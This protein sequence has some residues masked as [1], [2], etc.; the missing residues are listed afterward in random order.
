MHIAY[1]CMVKDMEMSCDEA[2]IAA[3]SV[4][5]RQYANA[6]LQVVAR[7]QNG[8]ALSAFA[9]GSIRSASPMC[10][11]SIVWAKVQLC[12]GRARSASLPLC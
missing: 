12:A 8:Y 9:H 2:A 10:L 5:R 4:D 7:P 3:L 6:L 1:R 11:R